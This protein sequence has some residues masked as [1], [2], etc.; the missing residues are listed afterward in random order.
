MVVE[1]GNTSVFPDVKTSPTVGEILQFAVLELLQVRVDDFPC[2]IPE[3]SALIEAL[4][5][6]EVTVNVASFVAVWV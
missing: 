5:S 3:G 1:F 6:A 4:R 2:K